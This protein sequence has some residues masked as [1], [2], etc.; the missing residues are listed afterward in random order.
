[1]VVADLEEPMPAIPADPDGVHQVVLNILAN[2]LDAVD[3]S[4]GVITIRTHYDQIGHEAQIILG[5]NGQGIPEDQLEKIFE[6]F[7]S[8]KGQGGT[9]LGLAVARKIVQEHGGQIA[10]SSP[11]GQG[12]LFTVTLPVQQNTNDSHGTHGP[13][14][15]T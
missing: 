6:V 13:G 7:H 10:V 15:S 1:M 8:T 14:S 5:D 3:Q 12:T 9:G 4:T 11:A 2:A